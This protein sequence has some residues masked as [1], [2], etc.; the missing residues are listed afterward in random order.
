MFAM[1]AQL[2]GYSGKHEYDTCIDMSKLYAWEYNY[3]PMDIKFN[4]GYLQQRSSPSL[5][6]GVS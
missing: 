6:F 5:G 1:V 4:A 3:D 2:H